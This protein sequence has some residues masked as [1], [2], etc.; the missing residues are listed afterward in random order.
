MIPKTIH[1]IWFSDE[2][3]P[4]KVEECMASWR[5]LLPDYEVRR[6]G[7]ADAAGIESEFLHEALAAGKWA[8]AADFLRLYAIY[9]YGGFYLDSD[10]RVLRSFDTL[11]A[12]GAFIG[13]ETSV[14][15]DGGRTECY[16]GAHC[17]GA[18][19]GNA[20]IGRC[21]SYYDGRRFVTSDDAT[22]PMTLKY[23]V[24]LLPFIMSEIAKESGYDSSALAD[25][26]QDCGA[27]RIYPSRY[28]DPQP[29]SAESY[30]LHM[31]LGSWRETVRY[32]PCYNL[33]YKIEWRV[34][35]LMARI[36]KKM[37]YMTVKLR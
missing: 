10:A 18:E 26:M 14:H 29:T 33:R 37:G 3:F 30:C 34:V 28:F 5:T 25:R 16:L 24:K 9:N 1:F 2:A 19:A 15:S 27:V 36:L 20:F 17:F 13:R 7:M 23:D 31:A 32:E 35:A 6:W 21:L 12:G 8:F 4:P 22:L 11:A